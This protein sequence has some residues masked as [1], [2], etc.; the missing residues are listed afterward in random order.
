MLE[1]QKSIFNR[2]LRWLVSTDRTLRCFF[3]GL[4]ASFSVLKASAMLPNFSYHSDETSES[5]VE[6]VAGVYTVLF[7]LCLCFGSCIIFIADLE[8]N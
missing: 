2:V 5:V 6:G 3:K 8:C 7:L 1:A 4:Q